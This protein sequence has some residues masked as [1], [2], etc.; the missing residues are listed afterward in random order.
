MQ[1]FSRAVMF[2]GCRRAT[3]TFNSLHR[4]SMGLRSGDWLGHSRT[5][6]C[7]LR[8]HSFVARA[9]CLGSLSCWKTQPRFIFKA[10]T[11]GRRFWLRISRYMAPFIL[12]LTRISRPVPLAEKQPQSMMF[13][14]PCFTV[15]MVFLGCNSVF[16]FLQIQRVE[17]IPKSSTLV[18]SDHMT[19][20]QSSA[21][22]SMCSLANFRR[23]WT[24]TG[25]S[26][27]TRLA[28]TTRGDLVND[29]QRAGTTVTK[30]T[31]SNTL[32][33]QGIK[34]CSARRV[35]LLKPVHVQA[36]LKFAR[37][38]MDDTAEDW[39]NVMWSDET[40]V[41]LFG[42]NSTRRVWRKKNT[43]LHPKNTIPT[44]KHGGG[45]IMLWGCFS[46]KGT[47]RLIRVKDRMN[48]AMYR[49]ILSQNLLPSVRALKMKRGW[50]FQ[51]DNDPK[52][53]ARAT[54][55]WLRKKHLK[56]LEWPSQSPD[57]NPIENMWRELKVCV[58]RRQPQN[59]TALEKIC[60]EE[61]STYDENYRPLS[62]F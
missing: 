40:K 23:A 55:E 48:G 10:L 29:L 35:P 30:V 34:S 16:F 31:I 24:C 3:R 52:H 57:L 9:V 39:E 14:P 36:R 43:E 13:P 26:S 21:V 47:G 27:G 38:H 25:F 5:F 22:S 20:S 53:T 33:R 37:E 54:K 2:W 18:S 8:S 1:I 12:S 17:F 19:F 56:V 45:N 60:M 11:D 15:G 51:H 50:V 28:L 32:Q 58:A 7:F 4:F 61:C 44:V 49:E 59:I 46:A 6:K 42:I 41:E 62:S